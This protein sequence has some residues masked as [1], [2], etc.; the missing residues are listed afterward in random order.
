MFRDSSY[1]HLST[2]EQYAHNAIFIYCEG[3]DW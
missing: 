3:S 1:V 2:Y